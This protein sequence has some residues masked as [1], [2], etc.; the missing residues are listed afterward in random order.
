[1]EFVITEE[2][3]EDW[4]IL[5]IVKKSPPLNWADLFGEEMMS[6]YESIQE[7]VGD[8]WF[9]YK[10]NLFRAFEL[11]PLGSVKCVILGQDPY[12]STIAGGPLIGQPTAQGLSFGSHPLDP[13]IPPSLKNIFKEL[14]DSKAIDK[15]PTNGDLSRWAKTGCLMLNTSLTVKPHQANSH[16]NLWMS[17][18]Y[19]VISILNEFNQDCIFVLWGKNASFYRKFIND[20]HPI[21]RTHP[22]PLSASKGFFGCNHFN[23]INDILKL[24]K[25]KLIKW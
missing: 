25:K 24:Q 18:I 3:Q 5:D 15:M 10:R 22:S 19:K 21:M 7:S 13:N 23:K 2:I 14:R 1:M 11:T 8:D 9:P 20:S 16:E 6:N 12:H 4:T 17:F